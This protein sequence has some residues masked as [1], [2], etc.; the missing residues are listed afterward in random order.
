MTSINLNHTQFLISAAAAKQFPSDNGAEVAFSGRSNA[1]KSSAINAITNIKN[2]A[3][4]SKTPGRTQ[5][6]NFFSLDDQY[7]LVD[8]PGYG[9]ADVPE[10]I[11]QRWQESLEHYFAQRQSLSGII[12]VSDIRHALNPFDQQML[13]FCDHYSLRTHILL[14][15]SD[16]LSRGA[17][18]AILEKIKKQLQDRETISLQLF[19]AKDGIGLESARNKVKG[20]LLAKA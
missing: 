7:R 3:R 9:Y 5:L 20:F 15:K 12:L 11:K 8:L 13:D 4:T 18:H 17:A 19:S 14:T 16:K 6:I 1:G 2:L 10:E